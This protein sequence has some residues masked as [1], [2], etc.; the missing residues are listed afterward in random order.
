MNRINRFILI[1]LSLVLSSVVLYLYIR[2]NT[3]KEPREIVA[4]FRIEAYRLDRYHLP[5][6]DV[7]LNQR[8]VGRTDENGLFRKDIRLIVGESYTL[9]IER[10][11]DGYVYGPW[12]TR[13]RV[14]EE[15][16]RKK[17]ARE[18]EIGEKP[19]PL[20]GDFDILTELERAQLGKASGYEKYN[21]LAIL[22]GYMFYTVEVTGRDG[23][24][25]RGAAVIVN[26]KEAGETDGKGKVEVR[27]SGEEQREEN[28]KIIKEGEH[29]WMSDMPV[30]PNTNIAA[31]LSKILLVD[32]DAFTEYY[33]SIVGVQN[34]SVYLGDQYMGSTDL[35]GRCSFK[36]ESEEGVDGYIELSIDYPEGFIPD[37]IR[38]VYLVTEALPKLSVVD[39]AYS[40]RPVP[41][42]I[43]VLPLDV[44]NKKDPQLIKIAGSMQ[45]GLEDYLEIGGVFTSVPYRNIAELFRQ[46]NVDFKSTAGWKDFPL[47]KDEVDAVVYG[48]IG[49]EK[50][51]HEISLLV[52]DYT[53][54]TLLEVNRRVTLRELQTLVED[55]SKEL[56]K[57]FP[58]EGNVTAIN[59][60]I[61][62]NLGRRFGLKKDQ[63]LYCFYNY[64]DERKKDFVKKSVARLRVVDP[65]ESVSA[66]E[67]VS[68]TE[69]YLL[70]SGIKVKRYRE[71]DTEEGP[72]PVQLFVT[73]K[74]KYIA[75]ANVYV[76]EYWSGQTNREGRLELSLLKNATVFISV[77]KEGYI[78]EERSLEVTDETVSLRTELKQGTTGLFL[79]T[80]PSEALV[81][82]DGE[83]RGT[84]PVLKKPLE[85]P[86]GF[87][88]L[89]IE[90]GGYKRYREYINFNEKK[91]ALTGDSKI[92]LFRDLMNE[93][94]RLY[95]D[96]RIEDTIELLRSITEEHP[97]YKKGLEFLGYILLHDVG[98]YDGAI[99]SYSIVLGTQEEDR[100]EPENI[101]T[102]YN[103]AQAYYNKA[104]KQFYTDSDLA[105]A[106]YLN[107]VRYLTIVRQYRSR[108]PSQQRKNVYQNA[109]F[110]LAV[111]FQKIY[112]LSG[113][114][115]YLSEAY[116]GWMSYFDFFDE[117]LLGEP[118]FKRQYS[119]AETYSEE[120]QRVKSEK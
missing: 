28:I 81:Y 11:S 22:D 50:N 113:K 41:P 67:L 25:S 54:E 20:E 13:F 68:I 58:F 42:K 55:F 43:V 45:T 19:S 4:P 114:Q 118:H 116:Y 94:E 73:A 29:I 97:D 36:Y 23:S 103:L 48:R 59:K 2:E 74:K 69:G 96:H 57:V 87:H 5:E 27:Y 53:G 120:V 100:V 38:R 86:Y 78:P 99:D 76:D 90:Y 60:L 62:I 18:S 101:L 111:S 64:F 84:S 110:Y 14:E 93:A 21:F 30:Y 117:R 72:V 8:F 109:L 70:E 92:V 35:S 24:P 119:V 61:Y 17:Q 56:K 26:G 65:G 83:Y 32:L 16:R 80:V 63:K 33:D 89:E 15:E 10:D 108:I 66:S 115:E 46:F 91:I 85:V 105:Q 71:P 34:A 37:R 77:Y 7:Y 102:Y 39:F 47:L 104:E 82:I 79:E 75:D 6:A 40:K 95:R 44:E 106:G 112:Y 12:E 107:A 88:L 31:E 3:S 9:R 98:D 49:G 1:F 51:L 52:K